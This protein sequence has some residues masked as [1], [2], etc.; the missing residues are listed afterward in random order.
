[1]VSSNRRTNILVCGGMPR[2]A[3][4]FLYGEISNHQNVFK[5]RIKESSL[6]TNYGW[7]VD[8]KLWLLNRK[9][10]YLD[11]SPE[12][13]FDTESL[14]RITE[15]D[16]HCFFI[17][18]NF[19]DYKISVQSYLDING[20]ENSRLGSLTQTQY[21]EAV[22][23]AKTNFLTFS[24][25]QVRSDVSTVI[26]EIQKR[27]QI[28]FGEKIQNGSNKNSSLAQQY[29][30]KSVLSNRFGKALNVMRYILFGI[31]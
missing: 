6:F 29:R 16:V 9:M 8:L 7:M 5:S 2:S 14:K 17:I 31:I 4:T 23:Y 19:N 3:T 15:R 22:D 24:F 25:D 30:I 18:R 12:Y 26:E 11:F 20:I 27:F 13:I 10:I 21:D 1:M 28:N